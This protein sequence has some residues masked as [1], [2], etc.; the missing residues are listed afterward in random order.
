MHREAKARVKLGRIA[1]KSP[2]RD[3]RSE[4]R[5]QSILEAHSK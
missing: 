5:E 2:G 3:F 1:G 4:P